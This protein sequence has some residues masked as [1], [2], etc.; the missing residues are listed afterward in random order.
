MLLRDDQI[1]RSSLI[2]PIRQREGSAIHLLSPAVDGEEVQAGK[3]IST[4]KIGGRHVDTVGWP[5]AGSV[6]AVGCQLPV[7]WV[8]LASVAPP[9]LTPNRPQPTPDWVCEHYPPPYC[10]VILQLRRAFMHKCITGG[11]AKKEELQSGTPL[12]SRLWR[13][14]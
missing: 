5:S 12:L 6:G 3:G 14:F 1:V 4:F 10:E 11:T 8:G 2:V 9:Q 7:S 13:P